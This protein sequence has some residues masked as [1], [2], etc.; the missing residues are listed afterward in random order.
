MFTLESRERNLVHTIA[1]YAYN[2]VPS[3]THVDR[4]I[5]SVVSNKE[6]IRDLFGGKLR[7]RASELDIEDTNA[8]EED[9]EDDDVGAF[10]LIC[11]TIGQNFSGFFFG[12]IPLTHDYVSNEAVKN[13]YKNFQSVLPS[14]EVQ[15]TCSNARSALLAPVEE[16]YEGDN[17]LIRLSYSFTYSRDKGVTVKVKPRIDFIRFM[18]GYLKT[19]PE[20]NIY[21]N[22]TPSGMKINKYLKTF[23]PADEEVHSRFDVLWSR[24]VQQLKITS[25]MDK[26][27]ISIA[28]ID[29][30]LHSEANT[31]GSCHSLD[32]ERGVAGWS[33]GLD[34][35]TAVAYMERDG[36]M[37]AKYPLDYPDK[38]WRMLVHIDVTKGVIVTGIPYPYSNASYFKT[39]KTGLMRLLADYHE[40]P[41]KWFSARGNMSRMHYGGLPY[42]D[43][44]HNSGACVR[45]RLKGMDGGSFGE[46]EEHI[47]TDDIRCISCGD[48]S[49]NPEQPFCCDCETAKCHCYRCE[50]PLHEDHAMWASDEPYCEECWNENFFRCSDCGDVAYREHAVLIA[51]EYHHAVCEYC[52]DAY[53]F[54]AGCEER[55]SATKTYLWNGRDEEEWCSDCAHDFTQE[56]CA[57]C[58]SAILFDSDFEGD[59]AYCDHCERPQEEAG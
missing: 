20:E 57:G 29:Y 3:V 28:P 49:E 54:C 9:S 15:T 12:N 17:R 43:M 46:S 50:D 2:S 7:I 21:E 58:G 35:V 33:L 10:D 51:G 59:M 32:G 18:L 41:R 24:V 25:D 8:V 38:S 27:T 1:D 34:N 42:P 16:L 31:W 5:D 53:P 56:V 14:C 23:L 6:E 52:A 44:N 45:L 47:G 11:R 37:Q 39:V 36:S 30:I 26:L 22:R 19:L 48:F 4:W 40:A 55:T 13:I